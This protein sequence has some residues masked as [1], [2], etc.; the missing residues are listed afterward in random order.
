MDA[1]KPTQFQKYK[2]TLKSRQLS[3]GER[4]QAQYY[5]ANKTLW[6]FGK[7]IKKLGNLH[8]LICLDGGYTLKR[9]INQLRAT[10]IEELNS[11]QISDTNF[12][13]N[14]SYQPSY[15]EDIV[16]LPKSPELPSLS[17][18][19]SAP[20]LLSPHSS[21]IPHS[22]PLMQDQDT[23]PLQSP[24][25]SPF[26]TPTNTFPT[27]PPQVQVP[28]VPPSAPQRKSLRIRRVPERLQYK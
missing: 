3:V 18:T 4:V 10:H 21:P 17:V 16:N 1:L 12:H 2:S 24:Y 28:I 13:Q 15:L 19:T 8:Y 7:V 20:Q 26:A 5:S 23:T 27:T 9:H 14:D 11:D 22:S 25:S 6:K